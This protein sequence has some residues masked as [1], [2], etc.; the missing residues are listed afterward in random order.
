[1]RSSECEYTNFPRT[2]TG[3]AFENLKISM[4]AVCSFDW[5]TVF[6]VDEYCDRVVV[7][8]FYASDLF[9]HQ[10]NQTIFIDGRYSQ[11]AHTHTHQLGMS[12]GKPKKINTK[13]KEKTV[14]K[15]HRINFPEKREN[16]D[17]FVGFSFLRYKLRLVKIETRKK[18]RFCFT[19]S[20]FA[21]WV[22]SH[23]DRPK[24][25]IY[26]YHIC[27]WRSTGQQKRRHCRCL[28]NSVLKWLPA[29]R[30][31]WQ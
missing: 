13:W 5:V 23:F 6:S 12:K 3:D 2:W 14:I 27:V 28:L 9:R 15:N 18:Q 30:W 11:R 21:E 25:S 8:E 22:C 26:P 24:A 4:P 10:R 29:T 16:H 19:R 7:F 31:K 20:S 1:M 17:S